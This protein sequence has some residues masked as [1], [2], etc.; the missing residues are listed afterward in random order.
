MRHRPIVNGAIG[1][2][3]GVGIFLTV[4][5]Q[6]LFSITYGAMHSEDESALVP[7]LVAFL[8][9]PSACLWIAVAVARAL[10]RGQP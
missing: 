3:V 7:M 2:A 6:I 8:L 5:V 9:V 10:N 4:G 1:V